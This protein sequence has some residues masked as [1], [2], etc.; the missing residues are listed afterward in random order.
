MADDKEAEVSNPSK[1][2]TT[3]IISVAVATIIYIIFLFLRS[4]NKKYFYR[5]CYVTNFGQDPCAPD[6]NKGMGI[7]SWI[8]YTLRYDSERYILPN[9]GGLDMVI[10]LKFLKYSFWLFTILTI[11]SCG[12]LLPTY[13]RGENAGR[14][15]SDPQYV[16]GLD[17]LT[18]SNLKEKSTKLWVPF[19]SV[20][21]FSVLVWIFMI[22]FWRKSMQ[23]NSMVNRENLVNSTSIM[24]ENLPKDITTNKEL[25]GDY[26]SIYRDNN[27]SHAVM[28]PAAKELRKL[29]NK[30]K[31]LAAKLKIAE[32]TAAETGVR[33]M[34]RPHKIP[35]SS[36]V[37]SI[38][39]YREE[40][41]QLDTMI[42]KEQKSYQH[43]DDPDNATKNTNVGFV[44]FRYVPIS[45][46]AAQNSVVDKVSPAERQITRRAPV[47]SDV[48]WK[49]L[50]MGYTARKIRSI[51][52]IVLFV[53]LFLFWTIPVTAITAISTL[54]TL[55]Q[56]GPFDFL[57]DFI[58]YNSFIS[59]IVQGFL[60]VWALIVFMALLPKILR[61]ITHLRGP[62]N[63]QDVERTVLKTYWA[64]LFLNVV[65]V[66]V[67]TG[68]AFAR[69]QSMISNPTDIPNLLAQALPTRTTFFA[70]YIL[71]R[72][73]SQYLFLSR[74]I[75]FIIS[76]ITKRLAKTRDEKAKKDIPGP[77]VIVE[78]LSNELLVFSIGIVYCTLGPLVNVFAMVYFGLSYLATK[79]N[80]M[81]ALTPSVERIKPT[82]TIV[83]IV[84]ASLIIYQV[85]MIGIF[86]L[87]YFP[88]GV[89]I[90]A[91]LIL[92]VLLYASLRRKYY[93]AFE[94]GVLSE[95][96]KEPKSEQYLH[97]VRM[98]YQDPAFKDPVDYMDKFELVY[99]G[100]QP[101]PDSQRKAVAADAL[102]S[103][104]EGGH[105]GNLDANA[106]VSNAIQ[107]K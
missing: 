1:L 32:D 58:N 2:Y 64:F 83:T 89:A 80:F 45:L 11:L 20:F 37:D 62:T 4:R 34:H 59:G 6:L 49:H 21:V 53:V 95:C 3:I 75:S 87:A 22:K 41:S 39:Y 88:A 43:Y 99:P 91:V 50:T 103:G 102:E 33:P 60:P 23:L 73:I 96:P 68:T 31:K 54:D 71:V 46:V 28:A 82:P 26:A 8:P 29:Q 93:N 13:I 9:Y 107:S 12:A 42:R 27:V 36:K 63:K 61:A 85:L 69:L 90:L 17:Q 14:P 94:Y 56:L 25:E 57:V 84:F 97:N 47:P 30:R 51:I 86:S 52:A 70:N 35:C 24:V 76:R 16:G 48:Y 92:T 105:H 72:Y 66:T 44:T 55:S 7:F 67:I 19:I 5:K 15:N 104:Y 79:H 65:L 40:V 100:A 106:F 98:A 81:Y 77:F 10:H 38:D 74:L 78:K 101:I 18:Y